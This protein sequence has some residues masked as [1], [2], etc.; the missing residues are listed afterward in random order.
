MKQS[1]ASTAT[2][3]RQ[4]A[5][6]KSLSP[7]AG[8]ASDAIK[9]ADAAPIASKKQVAD[10]GYSKAAAAA[11]ARAAARKAAAA[12]ETPVSDI[13]APA[14]AAAAAAD[15][16]A[17]FAAAAKAMEAEYAAEKGLKTKTSSPS[18]NTTTAVRHMSNASDVETELKVGAATAKAAEAATD[19]ATSAATAKAASE[20]RRAEPSRA[21]A[22]R[23]ARAGDQIKG[24]TKAAENAEA[25]KEA[26][27]S[28]TATQEPVGI[29]GEPLEEG[30]GYGALP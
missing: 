27:V 30:F 11:A 18:P 26:R 6:P 20:S 4:K 17:K 3:F 10:K 24:Y 15:K 21:E 29:H 22:I 19:E 5:P 12:A 28:A 23:N 13:L 2:S 1:A 25:A 8:S 14:K 9:E 16:E 7:E